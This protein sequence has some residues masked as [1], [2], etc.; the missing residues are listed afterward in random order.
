MGMPGIY[1]PLDGSEW[2][3]GSPD[4]VIRIVLYGLKGEV[5]V[6]GKMFNAAAMPAFGK[7]PNSA[8]NWSDEKIAA[9]LTYVRHAWNNTAAPITAEQVTAVHNAVG[10]RAE[11]SEADLNAVK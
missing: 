4:R 1:P 3:D 11:M 7:E 8:Y 6:E 2:V 10:V 9:V 5:H